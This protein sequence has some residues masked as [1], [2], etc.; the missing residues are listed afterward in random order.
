MRRV[1]AQ[2]M[3]V[4]KASEIYDDYAA[5]DTLDFALVSGQEAGEIGDESERYQLL[6]VACKQ[7]YFEVQIPA[8]GVQKLAKVKVQMF[9]SNV[10]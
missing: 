5:N 9:D 8:T 7:T 6:C 3:M 10:S 4:E 2:E 1:Y